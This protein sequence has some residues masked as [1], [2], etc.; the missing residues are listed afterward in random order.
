MILKIHPKGF[1]PSKRG[2][3][4]FM[5]CEEDNGGIVGWLVMDDVGDGGVVSICA[6]F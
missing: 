5:R 4:N 1:E 2:T 6:T 3:S